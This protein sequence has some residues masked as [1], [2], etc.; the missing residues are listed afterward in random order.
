MW[1]YILALVLGVAV[2]TAFAGSLKADPVR[3]DDGGGSEFENGGGGGLPP[4]PGAGDPDIPTKSSQARGIARR[5]HGAVG[6]S[7]G[8]GASVVKT[9]DW[10]WRF[11]VVFESILRRYTRI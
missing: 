4:P 10:T 3:G 9:S 7:A 6:V 1:A 5:S 2:A 11:A 8:D